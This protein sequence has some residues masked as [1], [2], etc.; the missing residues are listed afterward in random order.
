MVSTLTKKSDQRLLQSLDQP[1]NHQINHSTRRKGVVASIL[2]MKPQSPS[3]NLLLGVA[4]LLALAVL[5]SIL[6][7]LRISYHPYRGC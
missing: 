1:R 5:A 7:T 6:A 2:G 4:Y 3:R